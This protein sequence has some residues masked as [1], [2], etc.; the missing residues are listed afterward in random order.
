MPYG[1]RM[2]PWLC[3]VV[4]T[5]VLFAR[6]VVIGMPSIIR[7]KVRRGSFNFLN[8]VGGGFMVARR[9]R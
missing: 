7:E 5:A 9:P 3:L 6:D 2:V 8:L 4:S 1:G